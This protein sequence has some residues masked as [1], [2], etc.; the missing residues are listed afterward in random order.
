MGN[1]SGIAD[2]GLLE[3]VARGT[4][5]RLEGCEVARVGELIEVDDG[6]GRVLDQI[7]DNGRADESGSSSY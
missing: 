5:N 6:V 1:G 3:V 7:T 4:G 2:I